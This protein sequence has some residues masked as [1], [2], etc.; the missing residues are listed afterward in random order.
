M[1]GRLIGW[2]VGREPV[3]T[4]TGLAGGVAALVGVLA[5]FDVWRPSPEQTA[6][7]GALVAWVAG[8]LARRVVTPVAKTGP[9]VDETGGVWATIC[10]GFAIVF[11]L[12]FA[13]CVALGDG[14]PGEKGSLV[15]TEDNRPCE[16][17]CSGRQKKGC[18][19]AR[20]DCQDNDL[21]GNDV[22]V[23]LPQSHCE[24]HGKEGQA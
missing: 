24:F 1:I 18:A 3:A 21:N 2:V 8:Y 23:C 11:L 15:R 19:E 7:I 6:A 4:A 22:T 5:A 12:L 20:A 16:G 13:F 17:D 14:E 9:L 10:I